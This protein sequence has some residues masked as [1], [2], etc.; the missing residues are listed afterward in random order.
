MRDGQSAAPEFVGD[1]A[2]TAGRIAA[3]PA[4]CGPVTLVAVDGF[5]G[6]GKTTFADRLTACLGDAAVVHLDDLATHEE[7]FGWVGRLMDQVVLPLAAGRDARH[8]VYDWTRRRFHGERVIP[9]AAVV[10]LEGVGAGRRAVR[11]YLA[12]TL[13]MDVPS[14]TAQLHGRRRDGPA[15]SAFWRGWVRAEREHFAQDPTRPWA[16]LLV[17]GMPRQGRLMGL[18]DD[19]DSWGYEVRGNTVL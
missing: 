8:R 4:S 18:E 16:D 12:Q 6:S 7:P 15:L 5:A 10:V 2:A 1:A 13:W 9:C 11:R 3:L 17:R 19:A 14:H